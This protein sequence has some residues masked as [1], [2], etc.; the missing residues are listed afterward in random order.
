MS[1][2]S[3][4]KIDVDAWVKALG[5]LAVQMMELEEVSCHRGDH[6]TESLARFVFGKVEAVAYMLKRIKERRP[7]IDDGSNDSTEAPVANEG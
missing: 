2:I 4:V 1:E 6:A 7:E 5:N 3:S